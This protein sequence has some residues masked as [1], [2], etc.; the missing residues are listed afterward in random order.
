MNTLRIEGSPAHIKLHDFCGPAPLICF[1]CDIP[2]G[3]GCLRPLDRSTKFGDATLDHVVPPA[4]GGI[5]QRIN[6][7]PAC[8]SCNAQ[9]G[10][11]IWPHEWFHRHQENTW[12]TYA[13]VPRQA[14]DTLAMVGA[15]TL[16]REIPPYGGRARLIDLAAST[17]STPD[18]LRRA[19]EG[20]SDG[21]RLIRHVV[22]RG[23]GNADLEH[24]YGEAV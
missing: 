13:R 8:R 22:R 12:L 1:Y 15:A 19:L 2:L 24:V 20:L 21:K 6:T 9:K 4:R 3:C 23:P 17:G 14:T 18:E 10:Q 11:R 16:L 5:D 7:V